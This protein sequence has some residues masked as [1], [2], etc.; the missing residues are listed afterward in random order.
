MCIMLRILWTYIYTVYGLHYYY[1]FTNKV[2]ILPLF[3]YV[4]SL[5]T[6]DLF[7]LY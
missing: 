7:N 3:D 2:M 1:I 4:M 5:T 6:F